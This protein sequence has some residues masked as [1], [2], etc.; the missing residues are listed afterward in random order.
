MSHLNDGNNTPGTASSSSSVC[1]AA[2]RLETNFIKPD[3]THL[4]QDTT[5]VLVRSE[6][7]AYHALSDSNTHALS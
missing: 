3:Y 2:A 1:G 7:H 6:R 4:S 5:G